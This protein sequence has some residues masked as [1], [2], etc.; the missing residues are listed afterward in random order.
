MKKLKGLGSNFQMRDNG[1]KEVTL[2]LDV[3]LKNDYIH[4]Q[5]EEEK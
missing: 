3:R 1:A 2:M 4:C 5:V